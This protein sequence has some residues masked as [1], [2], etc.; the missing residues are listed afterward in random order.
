[1]SNITGRH[2]L[3]TVA[4]QAE[5]LARPSALA[6]MPSL[7]ILIPV[8]LSL[9]TTYPLGDAERDGRARRW[10]NTNSLMLVHMEIFERSTEDNSRDAK[11]NKKIRKELER[12]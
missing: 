10:T 4:E 3:E 12:D 1:L 7:R 11:L 6:V 2:L 9:K 8:W 5:R